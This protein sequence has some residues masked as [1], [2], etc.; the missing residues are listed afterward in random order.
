[1]RHVDDSLGQSDLEVDDNEEVDEWT[2]V[3]R[4]R[5]WRHDAIM[6]HLY[7]TA[8]FW[9]DK[10]LSFTNDPND[11]FWLAQ[12]YFLAH[13]YARAEQL[14]TRPF[15]SSPPAKPNP[16]LNGR[17]DAFEAPA[18]K[19]PG[20]PFLQFT[21]A[22]PTEDNPQR[23][24]DI[25]ISCR[26]LAA[27]CQVRQGKWPEAMETLGEANPWRGTGKSGPDMPNMDGG[28]KLDSSMCHLRGLLMLKMNRTDK[29]KECFLEALT[30]DVKNYES[31][32]MLVNG[33]MM[34]VDEE[35][36]VIQ[37]LAFQ[38][39]AREEAEFVKMMYTIRLKKYKHFEEM[40]LARRR[41]VQ[42][43][44]LIDNCDVL[45]G[46]ADALYAQFR[47]ADCFALTSR[48][49]D[50]VNVHPPSMPLHI[51]CMHHL[52]YLQSKLF[53][54]AH[55]LVDKEPEAAMSWYAVGVWYL[56]SK[57]WAEAR[58]FFSKTSLMDPRFAP[59]WIA[60]AHSFAQEGEHDH[61]ITAYATCARLFQGTHLPLMFTG[62]EHIRLS[63]HDAADAALGAANKMC[64][65]D[66][67]LVNEMGVMAYTRG[68][69]ERAVTLLEKALALAQV[70]QSSRAHWV[71]V[72]VNL[73]SAY[74]KVGRLQD[75]K[76]MYQ[77]VLEVDPRHAMALGFL[78]LV[79]HML[80]DL[81]QA[82]LTYHEA[83][84]IEPTNQ[85][86]LDLLNLAL[87]SNIETPPF[88]RAP[89]APMWDAIVKE[90]RDAKGRVFGVI[91]AE[92]AILQAE[93]SRTSQTQTQA[94]ASGA[95]DDSM[96][97]LS[98]DSSR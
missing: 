44:G 22:V 61:A 66:P 75:A 97:D 76:K 42:E 12:S 81:D 13:Q 74:R 72:Q 88:A 2:L 77:Q 4:M 58:K 64:A 25:S 89:G 71:G 7:S 17:V 6:Q 8:A 38:E 35:W 18:P 94:E 29:A 46:F 43:Y 56:T 68:D 51:A 40:A 37:G 84:S 24:V 5:L 33:E 96:M 11:A 52:S 47:W 34:T 19:A 41:L 45:H 26:Y 36:H 78:G 92:A 98:V 28:I 91:P 27:Q 82:I 95:G 1:M 60:F 86:V 55:E 87:E 50:L 49:L 15:P 63:H 23:L 21:G 69:F 14:L 39:H 57:K 79:Y 20:S 65:T 62:M 73:G 10:I 9:G 54:L 70:V 48:I 85:Y 30:L 59:A 83:L 53:M 32:E 80:D 93:F 90:R 67:L 3:D 31:F 16:G